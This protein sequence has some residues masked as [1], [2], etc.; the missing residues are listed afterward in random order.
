[1]EKF[2]LTLKSF[3]STSLLVSKHNS[4]R[5]L[6]NA[7]RLVE[8]QKKKMS[9]NFSDRELNKSTGANVA[10]ASNKKFRPRKNPTATLVTLAASNTAA[11][12]TANVPARDKLGN[13]SNPNAKFIPTATKPQRC[14]DA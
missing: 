2:K 11:M 12:M 5:E 1:M 14:I 6:L 10:T 4:L 7:A 8:K 9:S 13:L 3:I